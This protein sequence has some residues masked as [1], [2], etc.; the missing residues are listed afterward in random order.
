MSN[1]WHTTVCT[2]DEVVCCRFRHDETDEANE[3][4]K[5][6]TRHYCSM[7]LVLDIVFLSNTN[8]MASWQTTGPMS[9]ST[10]MQFCLYHPTEGY[11][12]NPSLPVFGSRGDFTTSPEI[13]QVF[14]EVRLAVMSTLSPNSK[15]VTDHS[16]ISPPA[17]L[18]SYSP[19]GT[20]RKSKL[21]RRQN[22]SDSSNWDPVEGR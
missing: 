9:M 7:F 20:C 5:A 14:G 16:V 3:R 22:P 13:S 11:Y 19:F 15:R 21:H 6:H 4:G 17:V 8:L 12:M 1:N 2:M 18:S 10:Y